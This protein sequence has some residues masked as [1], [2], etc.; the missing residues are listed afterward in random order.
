MI[1]REI[2]EK[3]AKRLFKGKA[4][5]I[6]G[7]RQVGKT[8]IARSISQSAG[9]KTLWLNC[10]ELDT[11]EMLRNANSTNLK[12]ITNGYKIVVIDEAQRVEDIGIVIKI[13]T[14]ALPGIQVI[15]TGSASF[16]LAQK[17]NEPLTGRKY[18]FHIYPLSFDEMTKHHGLLEEKRMIDHRLIFGYYPE[19]VNK[20]EEEK[21]LLS[22]LASSYLYKDILTFDRIKK[23]ELVEKLVKALALQV[24]NE[25]SYN[26]LST[27]VGADKNTVEKYIGILEKAFVIFRL[28][29][30]SG[31]IRNE[32]KKSR[33]IY[34]YDNGILN[35]VISNY[36]N[37]QKRNDKGALWENFIVSE[38]KKI[39]NNAGINYKQNFWRTTQQQEIDLI[40]QTPEG[41]NAFEIKWNSRNFRLP[42]TFTSNYDIIENSCIDK[43]NFDK[44]LKII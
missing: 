31:N 15:A 38:R 10:D 41:M 1:K 37:I 9:V 8:T 40:E 35:S 33:K 27:L 4:I 34:F 16:E 13:F 29:A 26:E 5:I 24:G 2:Q 21:E 17:I 6:Y 28:E 18:E 22:M 20:Q 42:S 32:I 39:F 44:Y 19:I 36:S 12:N 25:V 11:R 43:S 23:P 14:D 30:L 7:A 3:I